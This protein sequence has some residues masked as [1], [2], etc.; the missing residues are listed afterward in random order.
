MRQRARWKNLE[1]GGLPRVVGVVSSPDFPGAK[2]LS[3]DLVE[4]RLDSLP[5]NFDWLRT[6]REIEAAGWPVILTARLK[7]EG[8][9]WMR[10]DAERRQ[11]FFRAL[12]NFS[13]A[14]VEL[15]SE[16]AAEV[17]AEARRLNKVA[18]V[19]H[20]DF[21][22]TPPLDELKQI[23]ARAEKLGTV[24]K[25]ATMINSGADVKILETLLAEK[26]EAPLCVI[27]MGAVAAE[28]RVSFAMRGS[29]LTYGF[30]GGQPSAPGQ[31]SA[32]E[33]V[34]RLRDASPE[35]DADFLARRQGARRS[36][37]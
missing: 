15:Q 18:I 20:H 7:M 9:H 27:G 26:I 8:G 10:P 22:K 29:C 32:A 1:L 5:E 14:D 24:V 6:G 21:S 33:L 12:E 34:K 28:T 19:S 31:L 11:V 23:A 35:Y 4:I 3:C 25:L 17:C 13:A 30:L 36:S 37:N 2:N 16:I